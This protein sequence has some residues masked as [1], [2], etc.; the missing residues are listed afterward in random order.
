MGYVERNLLPD[1]K[2]MLKAKV[3]D[4]VLIGPVVYVLF[5]IIVALVILVLNSIVQGYFC[6]M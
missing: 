4:I 5:L 1:E 6:K 2:I 3:H